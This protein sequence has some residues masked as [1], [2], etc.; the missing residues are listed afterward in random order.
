VNAHDVQLTMLEA[1]VALTL[2]ILGSLFAAL[3]PAWIAS[4]VQPVEAMRRDVAMGTG[5]VALRSWPTVTAAI[6]FVLAVPALW[7]PP[8]V[9]NFAVGGYVSIFLIL[10]GVTLASPLLLRRLN[11]PF[12]GPGEAVLGV[13]GRLAADNFARAPVRT[14]VP[15]SAMTVGVAMS[16]TVAAFVGSF[17]KSAE[18]WIDQAIPADLFVTAAAA[19]AGTQNQPMDPALGNELLK[20]AGVSDIDMVRIYPADVLDLRVFIISLKPSV[21]SKRGKPQILD[22]HLADEA[23][24]QQGWVTISENLARR[25]NLKVGTP[26]E[27]NTPTGVHT[28]RPSAIIIDYTSDQGSIIMGR[29]IFERDFKDDRVDS[30]HVYVDDPSHIT[31]VRKTITERFG[32]EYNLYVLTNAELRKE[33]TSLIDNAFSVTYAMQ[34]VAV[35]LALLGVINTLLAAVLDRTREIGLLRA[36]GATRRH[37]IRLF[38]GEATYIGVTGGVLG[39]LTGSVLG[40]ILTRVV[41]VQVTGWNIA[42]HFPWQVSLQMLLAAT[43]CAVLAGLYPARR[44]AKLEVVEALA[45]E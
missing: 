35:L 10:M 31:Q 13:A 18:D 36:V 23:E 32:K 5:H 8:P 38:I 22:G 1:V 7:I 21:Y 28:Y 6:L 40:Y 39:I 34:V 44:A 25:R 2:G 4:G 14:A 9:E 24:R 3:R 26:F 42:F 12:A 15:V 30:F 11:H 43:A 27:I 29:E 20:I 45:W 17:Q 16:V 41:G 33:A 37:V 19:V